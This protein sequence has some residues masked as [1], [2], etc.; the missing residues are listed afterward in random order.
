MLGVVIDVAEELLV[1]SL[2]HLLKRWQVR[3]T[4]AA[5]LAAAEECV[6]SLSVGDCGE[7][8]PSTGRIQ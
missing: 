6:N 3:W 8:T 4:E 7:S 5:S 1:G 2:Q